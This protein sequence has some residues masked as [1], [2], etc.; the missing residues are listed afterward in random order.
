MK[1]KIDKSVVIT[2]KD[3]NTFLSIIE[4]TNRQKISKDT[5]DLVSTIN[6]L[7]LIGI[8]NTPPNNCIIIHIIL[9]CTWELYQKKPFGHKTSLDKCKVFKS[10][11]VCTLTTTK[12]N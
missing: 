9:K 1:R 6:Q 7:H 8:Q 2:V 10:Y 4:R 11:K 12:L 3:F 5:E